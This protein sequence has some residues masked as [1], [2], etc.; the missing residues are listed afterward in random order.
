MRTGHQEQVDTVMLRG[1]WEEAHRSLQ[2]AQRGTWLV[3]GRDGALETC[4]VYF[5]GQS[6][7]LTASHTQT[8]QMY[9]Y[10]KGKLPSTLTATAVL[11]PSGLRTDY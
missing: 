3:L 2:E 9:R 4:D 11:G 1:V 10:L 7:S 5:T 8:D 6:M